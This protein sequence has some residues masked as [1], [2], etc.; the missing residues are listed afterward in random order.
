MPC[1]PAVPRRPA[2]VPFLAAALLAGPLALTG[3]GGLEAQEPEAE[4]AEIVPG[5][6]PWS[7]APSPEIR[8]REVVFESDGV[9]LAG[10]LHFPEGAGSGPALV[11]VQQGGTQ[12]RENPLFAQ[13]A[14]L[15][16]RLGYSVLLYDRRGHGESGGSPEARDYTILAEDA[17]A[18]MRAIGEL[19]EV[20]PD[21]IGYWGI[22]QGGWLA[23][24]AGARS[25]AAFVVSVSAPLTP[26]DEQMETLAHNYVLVG[27]HGEDAARGAAEARRAVAGEYFRGERSRASAQEI[28]REIRDEPWFELAFLP[29]PEELPE[30]PTGSPWLSEMRFDPARAFE[31]LDAPLLFLLG[32]EDLD[33]PVERTLAI[34]DSIGEGENREVV[35]VPGASHLMR[36]E[37]D[38]R[39]QLELDGSAVSNAEAYFMLV[40]EWLGR[41]GL[42]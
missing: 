5:E 39:D 4:S 7:V 8:Q 12:S 33:V 23:M 3:S 10:T 41:L 34:A 18:G 9:E 42:E 36:V 16:A 11:V 1:R 15:F 13:V 32:G 40:G 2:V 35:V 38:P 25:D 28:L 26:P 17:V 21:E 14:E 19:D 29:Q 27:G 31:E 37:E 22:S 30:D 24:I 20:D 6:A